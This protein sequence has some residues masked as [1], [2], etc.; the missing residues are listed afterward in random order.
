M[1]KYQWTSTRAFHLGLIASVIAICLVSTAFGQRPGR[2]RVPVVKTPPVA[3]PATTSATIKLPIKGFA[4]LHTHQMGH[5]NFD[6]GWLWGKPSG[7]IATAL[8]A[9]PMN[10]LHGLAVILGR[11][12]HTQRTQGNPSFRDW[13]SWDNISHQS[14]YETW[15]KKAHDEG[16][17]LIVVSYTNFEP[18]CRALKLMSAKG[19]VPNLTAC[20][21]MLVIDKQHEAVLEFERT[22]SWYKVVR[23]PAE[24][25]KAISD[26]KL[27]VVLSI[28]VSN[29]FDEDKF[30]AWRDQLE[31]WHRKGVR[32][33][34]PVHE[35]DNRFGRAATHD[36]TFAILDVLKSHKN[37]DDQQTL[38]SE[39]L[40][41]NANKDAG[42]T[43]K[44]EALIRAMMDKKMLID[45]AHLDTPG[46]N[47]VISITRQNSFYP[48]YNSHTYFHETMT[49]DQK[50]KTKH[51][52]S[53][54]VD[55][56]KKSGGLIG[57][58]TGP[59][60]QV[61]FKPGGV[62]NTCHG[63]S[64]SFAQGYAFATMGMK[65]PVAFGT[66]MNGMIE[67]LGPR[68]ASGDD[69]CSWA[70]KHC[71]KLNKL[72]GQCDAYKDERT[73]QQALQGTA[74]RSG[75]GTDFDTKGFAR[76]DHMNDLANDLAKLGLD[77]DPLN[78]GAENFIRMWERAEASSRSELPGIDSFKN[79]RCGTANSDFECEMSKSERNDWA[80]EQKKEGDCKTDDDCGNGLYCDKGTATVGRNTCKRALTD[81]SVCERAGQCA[82]GTCA[83][84]RCVTPMSKR[85]GDAC[86]VNQECQMGK[87]SAALFGVVNGKCVCDSDI[88]CSSSQYC[89]KGF[90][91]I[92]TNECRAKKADGQTCTQAA[93]CAGGACRAATCY[94]PESKNMGQ[95]C[96]FNAECR[97]GKCSA[98]LLGLVNGKCVCENNADCGS[99]NY[100]DKGTLGVG[101]NTCKA[102][103]AQGVS[104]TAGDQCRS[105]RCN[106]ITGCRP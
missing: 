81:G 40:V 38:I 20:S 77:T 13:P 83:S 92:G 12:G 100:C 52:D 6:G 1:S 98:E 58:R 26:G 67:S 69:S 93:D 30:G 88:H 61:K 23:S 74:S 36:P 95:S 5:L 14:I 43:D 17:K 45:V 25:R 4:D 50:K 33:I 104:C 91:D 34:Q 102:K 94:T 11:D 41:P 85:M 27:A 19:T 79:G 24:A 39:V 53:R 48:F 46:I 21:D 90:A 7:P 42:L 89:Y 76:I 66:D 78:D 28:E 9:C 82:S 3:K 18:L 84:L 56:I 54:I 97:Q 29:L 51:I 105:G 68:F 63:S 32:S 65:V 31:D 62:D 86:Y 64:R 99:G 72:V 55:A 8:D 60:E 106:I 15:L 2:P 73:Q 44:G 22:H 47:E 70:Y 16:L 87:C 75:I 35:I 71:S 96:N 37:L 57:L 103:K 101:T 80:K 49:E 10:E 59:E